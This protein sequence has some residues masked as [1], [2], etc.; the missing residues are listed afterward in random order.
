MKYIQS[1]IK[2]RIAYLSIHRTEKRNALNNTVVEEL[3]SMFNEHENNDLVK[4]IVITGSGNTFCAGADLDYLKQLQQNTYEEN[5]TD[6]KQLMNLYKLIYNSHK[7]TVAQINGHAI[8]GGCG[9]VTVCDFA[10]SIPEANFGYTET[11]IGFV[12]AIV[13]AF[14]IR[15]IGLSKT[16][17]LTLTGNVINANAALNYGLI[18]AI[19]DDHEKLEKHVHEFVLDII[20]HNSFESLKMTKQLIQKLHELDLNDSLDYAAETNA[21][22]RNSNDCK[23]GIQAFLDKTKVE[24]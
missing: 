12:P 22:A 14:L 16:K 5:L 17:E 2:N 15:K 4:A 20:T 1:E 23:K 18:N 21:K 19:L 11:R 10:F 6:S 13:M 9:L 8:A 24:W 3:T 7:I